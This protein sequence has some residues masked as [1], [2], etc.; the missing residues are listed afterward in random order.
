K[1]DWDVCF[2]LGWA[3]LAANSNIDYQVSFSGSEEIRYPF[4]V[5]TS[6]SAIMS[7]VKLKK[8]WES[9]F[10]SLGFTWERTEIDDKSILFYSDGA[11]VF[12]PFPE[13]EFTQMI[14]DI[15]L[16]YLF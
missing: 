15:S 2:S 4:Q 1:S 12:F 8:G 9:F 3:F 11:D 7:S 5:D 10:L 13:M 16:S 14:G 6:G